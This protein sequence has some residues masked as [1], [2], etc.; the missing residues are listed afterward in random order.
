MVLKIEQR[1]KALMS[2]YR[3]AFGE[4]EPEIK[5]KLNGR[6]SAI[7]VEIDEARLKQIR[8]SANGEQFALL[9]DEGAWEQ[10]GYASQ[11]EADLALVGVLRFWV[12]E[13]GGPSAIDTYFRASAL[14]RD[15]WDEQRGNQT[16]GERT[17]AQAS[18]GDFEYYGQDRRPQSRSPSSPAPSDNGA[19]PP[20][21]EQRAKSKAQAA[22]PKQERFAEFD[23]TFAQE[24]R[25]QAPKLPLEVF[26]NWAAW[27]KGQAK[28]KSAPVDFVA[29]TL[30]TT[31]ASLIGNARW[32]SPWKGWE[33]PPTLWIA[34][35]GFPSSG[36]TPAAQPIYDILSRLEWELAQ[37]YDA[38]K[39]KWKQKSVEIKIAQ[40]KWQADFKNPPTDTDKPVKRASGSSATSMPLEEPAPVYPRLLT[41]DTTI[42][43]LG[44][45]LAC[46]AKGI[47]H[48][49]DE[50]SG[51]LGSFDQ[52]KSA[53]GGER[54]FWV[55]AYNGHSYK[56]DRVKKDEPTLIKHLTVSID[57][58]LQPDGI[59][60]LFKGV[61]DGLIAR[62]LTIW[63]DEVELRRPKGEPSLQTARDALRWLRDLKMDG[64]DY[65]LVS[66]NA[67]AAN[68]FEQWWSQEFKAGE[69][70]LSGKFKS[71]YGKLSGVVLRLALVLTYLR[72]CSE[73]GQ[74][75]SEIPL[76]CVAD[77]LKLA[78][79]YFLPME[80][81]VFG[82]SAL[83]ET[84]RDAKLIARL[85]K[86]RQ[87]VSERNGRSIINLHEFHH[88]YFNQMTTEAVQAA[89]AKLVEVGWLVAAQSATIRAGRP[90]KDYEVNP[91]AFKLK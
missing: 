80:R 79:D 20:Q 78:K 84:E 77:A 37:T 59:A 38:D 42:E 44:E 21:Q 1:Q 40:A 10:A 11:S 65:K 91:R 2:I 14:M 39:Q 30:L 54:S 45:I 58:G 64:D 7:A 26:G 73:G 22:P 19:A 57:G 89:A 9:F 46:R 76:A 41:N 53:K 51:W 52:Y 16:Y 86:E 50:L 15:K 56:I 71:W 69:R 23:P 74:E 47:L 75:P 88:K 6:P 70:A 90:R 25:E 28:A 49:R 3:E 36:K 13:L 5:P 83:Q 18:K 35:I 8:E 82:E 62:L 34:R 55:E 24:H 81:R 29:A 4:P 68:F 12:W 33:G 60:A 27:L 43:K 61:D 67:E 63:P 66:F 32:V 48:R 31:A 85:I 87:F 17:V 72:W